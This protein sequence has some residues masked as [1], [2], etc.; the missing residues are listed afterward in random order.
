M[1]KFTHGNKASKGRPKGAVNKRSVE[2]MAVLAK[3]DFCPA[4]AMIEVYT[5]A[6]KIYSSY[7]KIYDAITGA[8]EIK[9]M[10][11]LEDKADKYLRIAGDMAKELASFAYPKKK[12][13]ENTVDPE[14]LEKFRELEGKTDE[15]LRAIVNSPSGT[16]K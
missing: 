15:E 16:L 2:F 9:G 4:S 6:K 11:P 14:L 8:R 3:H 5:E 10:L 1:P 12:A 7:A 13:I